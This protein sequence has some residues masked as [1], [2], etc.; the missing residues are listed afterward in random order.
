[1]FVVECK[2]YLS[3]SA[4]YSQRPAYQPPRRLV[5][6]TGQFDCLLVS[7]QVVALNHI[8]PQAACAFS[9]PTRYFYANKWHSS[10]SSSSFFTTIR[11]TSERYLSMFPETYIKLFPHSEVSSSHAAS[12]RTLPPLHSIVSSGRDIAGTTPCGHLL[13][14]YKRPAP[15]PCSP[16]GQSTP[17]LYG[18]INQASAT[19][20]PQVCQV[21]PFYSAFCYTHPGI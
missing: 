7:S 8:H 2:K 16:V 18:N 9:P 13:G 15:Q 17:K 6:G 3:G 12:H 20:V 5:V 1:M 4:V 14:L 21:G 10:S 11:R 19:N